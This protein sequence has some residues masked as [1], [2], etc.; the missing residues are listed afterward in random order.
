MFVKKSFVFFSITVI[1]AYWRDE[2]FQISTHSRT[3]FKSEGHALFHDH[4]LLSICGGWIDDD[5]GQLS[6]RHRQSSDL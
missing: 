6:D 4:F 2:S 1:N 3:D 5:S